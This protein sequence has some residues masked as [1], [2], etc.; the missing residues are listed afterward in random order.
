MVLKTHQLDTCRQ[1]PL[2]RVTFGKFST[3]RRSSRLLT[4]SPHCILTMTSG[5]RIT[6][7]L[8]RDL[9]ATGGQ[10]SSK[11]ITDGQ[12]SS[13]RATDGQST[14]KRATIQSRRAK[15]PDTLLSQKSTH[16]TRGRSA[17]SRRN[18]KSPSPPDN[19]PETAT[20]SADERP[21]NNGKRGVPTK[22]RTGVHKG[23]GTSHIRR[24][25]SPHDSSHTA[26]TD[27]G[28]ERRSNV[29]KRG[30][31]TRGRSVPKKGRGS[32]LSKRH[33]FH[34]YRKDDSESGTEADTEIDSYFE[35]GA[36]THGR[37]A[38]TAK[39]DNR[40][41]RTKSRTVKG[42]EAPDSKVKRAKYAKAD[43][44]DNRY[45]RTKSRMVKGARPDGAEEGSSVTHDEVDDDHEH[46][47]DLDEADH[48]VATPEPLVSKKKSRKKSKTSKLN[49]NTG[50]SSKT[51]HFS[52]KSGENIAFESSGRKAKSFNYLREWPGMDYYRSRPSEF[53]D[54]PEVG[55]SD[56]LEDSDMGEAPEWPKSQ[57]SSKLRSLRVAG[58]N[59]LKVGN[60]SARN[61]FVLIYVNNP[62]SSGSK[63]FLSPSGIL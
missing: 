7:T 22:G 6:R 62:T 25:P 59:L 58:E 15:Q 49:S 46:W 51:V 16:S 11:R 29:A 61:T 9:E 1:G 28:D 53:P 18:Q 42:K 56:S 50:E 27:S 57:F 26:L 43:N 31:A 30:G 14:S 13:K 5:R 37:R 38:K 48:T 39:A 21:S 45:T 17:T 55:F 36:D 3:N 12:T 47:E 10:S 19:S 41:T 60:G 54:L 33:T 40:Y 34:N 23:R 44:H 8:S 32:S 20:E 24:S 35:E 2:L 52:R 4:S 63:L